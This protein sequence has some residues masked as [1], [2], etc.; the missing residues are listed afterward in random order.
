[1]R[2]DPDFDSS[3]AQ[4][5]V[6]AR[7]FSEITYEI[8]THFESNDALIDTALSIILLIRNAG[9]Q[10]SKLKNDCARMLRAGHL[11]KRYLEIYG[12]VDMPELL[13][14]LKKGESFKFTA[15]L[16]FISKACTRWKTQFSR[17]KTLESERR[18]RK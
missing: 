12:L 18:I 8:I 6:I 17:L 9:M 13:D 1:M 10:A 7:Y 2:Y 15:N 14:L 4:A 3:S 5:Q 11:N 16:I